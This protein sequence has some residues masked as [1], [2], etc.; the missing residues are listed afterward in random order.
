M[1]YI[2]IY[3][4]T[5]I[6]YLCCK[7]TQSDKAKRFSLKLAKELDKSVKKRKKVNRWYYWL[8]RHLKC[9]SLSRTTKILIYKTLSGHSSHI[10]QDANESPRI[11][12]TEIRGKDFNTLPVL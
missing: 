5:Y 3:Y 10:H 12:V 9:K 2:F 1:Y 11:F 6:I 7:S 8:Q 4:K